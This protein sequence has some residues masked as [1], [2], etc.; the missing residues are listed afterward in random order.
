MPADAAFRSSRRSVTSSSSTS[1]SRGEMPVSLSAQAELNRSRPPLSAKRALTAWRRADLV[2][3]G[4]HEFRHTFGSLLIAAGVNAK[5]ITADLGHASI[6]TTLDPYG[7]LMPG[8]EDE[9][10]ALVDAYRGRAD[11]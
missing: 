3:F 1:S 2:P 4:L 11:S 6:Q 7:Q 10:G 9:A 5:A 8:N